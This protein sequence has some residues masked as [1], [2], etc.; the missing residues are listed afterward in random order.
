[1]RRWFTYFTCCFVEQGGLQS[2]ERAQAWAVKGPRLTWWGKACSFMPLW[3][4]SIQRSI[5]AM[6]SHE[7]EKREDP[8][9][10]EQTG[11]EILNEKKKWMN[12]RTDMYCF[13]P[14]LCAWHSC[15]LPRDYLLV[16]LL[17]P[18]LVFTCSIWYS[19]C[20]FK[21]QKKRHFR[22]HIAAQL[23]IPKRIKDEK[24]ESY[25]LRQVG[26]SRAVA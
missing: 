21:F 5:S 23:V 12:S 22:P 6:K 25:S 15:H 3:G 2:Q 16:V 10:T 18:I 9:Q 14:P 17:L 8:S 19:F 20:Q 13:P 11:K 7:K 4:N 24:G 26:D 1:M